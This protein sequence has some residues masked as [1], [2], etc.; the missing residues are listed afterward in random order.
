MFDCVVLMEVDIYVYIT[1]AV[2]EVI[3]K[4]TSKLTYGNAIL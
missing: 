3:A 4:H 2:S 1:S